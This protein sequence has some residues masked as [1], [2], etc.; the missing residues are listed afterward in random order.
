[1]KFIIFQN[2]DSV[3][4]PLGY[5][6]SVKI[7]YLLSFTTISIGIGEE[8]YYIF[9]DAKKHS[10]QAKLNYIKISEEQEESE[11]VDVEDALKRLKNLKNKNSKH[12]LLIKQLEN[13][14][15]KMFQILIEA[16]Y[17][18]LEK[19]FGLKTMKDLLDPEDFFFY[20]T[21]AENLI[22]ENSKMT[23][24]IDILQ[25][26]VPPE[27]GNPLFFLN[28]P[29]TES[30][31][32]LDN[33]SD[34]SAALLSSFYGAALLNFPN[35]SIITTNQ[36]SLVREELSIESSKFREKL[37]AWTNICYENPNTTLGLDYFRENLMK[38]VES[39][40]EIANQSQ[41]LKNFSSYTNNQG[42]IDVLFGEA[43]IEK[44]W[45]IYLDT[46][47]ISQEIF[48][49]L[50]EIKKE[51]SPKFDGRWTVAVIETKKSIYSDMPHAEDGM[52]SV[53]KSISLD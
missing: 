3:N 1:M 21:T 53:R 40:D 25:L 11:I 2:L 37:T 10:L 41:I 23:P 9:D 49:K 19:Q 34:E 17:N 13:N 16:H 47:T 7:S 39:S 26:L 15:D 22:D 32:N 28:L 29:Y 46:N 38:H 6:Y 43:P 51:Q 4:N 18:F 27:K 48:D 45:Q 36:I 52:K 8:A 35:L 14:I 44:I 31:E 50:H 20:L 42:S 30:E 5:N 24:I 12:F 33:P